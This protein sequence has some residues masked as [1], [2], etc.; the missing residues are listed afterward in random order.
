MC[1][2]VCSGDSMSK[3]TVQFCSHLFGETIISFNKGWGQVV[4]RL[5]RLSLFIGWTNKV[6]K[7]EQLWQTSLSLCFSKTYLESDHYLH[8]I[9]RPWGEFPNAST[10][11]YFSLW[12]QNVHDKLGSNSWIPEKSF[13]NWTLLMLRACR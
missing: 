2:G 1:L 4:R 10:K 5:S 13:Q 8:T 11:S 3:W 9:F 12:R 6:S 7:R